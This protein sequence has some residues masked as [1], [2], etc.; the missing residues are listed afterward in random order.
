MEYPVNI[1]S[2]ET[3]SKALLKKLRR[4]K[5]IPAV[6]YGVDLDSRAVWV[7]GKEILK[8]ISRSK[9]SVLELNDGEK[10]IKAIIKDI[11]YN[12][13][14]EEINH[15]DFLRLQAKHELELKVPVR[16]VGSCPGVKEGGVLDF[17]TREL[18][19][20]T[21][22][23]KIPHELQIDVSALEI[24]RVLKVSDIEI[25]EG[26]TVL[27]PGDTI[28]ITV[29]APRK[30]E[31]APAAAEAGEAEPEVVKKGK[32]AKETEEPEGKDKEKGKE[33]EEPAPAVKKEKKGK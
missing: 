13:L 32:E 12:P 29:K 33:K 3:G 19:I 7:D 28:C 31:E 5:K 1:N 11:S 18:E 23:S 21:I 14:T 9:T 30:E 2:R 24:G 10:K 16:M 22:P 26:I 15:I 17:V 4:E 8:I 27:T 25:P 20:K 6:V